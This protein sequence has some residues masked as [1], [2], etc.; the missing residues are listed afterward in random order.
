MFYVP[1]V[2]YFW[3]LRYPRYLYYYSRRST[4]VRYPLLPLHPERRAPLA[5]SRRWATTGGAAGCGRRCCHP[6]WRWLTIGYACLQ[7][8]GQRQS[9]AK[10]VAL[11]VAMGSALT[12]IATAL[13]QAPVTIGTSRPPCWRAPGLIQ[14]CVPRLGTCRHTSHRVTRTVPTPSKTCC[15]GCSWSRA[16]S[17]LWW[18]PRLGAPRR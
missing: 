16:G 6:A 15:T 18:A 13:Q 17:G 9:P 10:P 14:Q 4:V 7:D 5:A 11:H 2:L 8:T 3:D 12:A 1:I